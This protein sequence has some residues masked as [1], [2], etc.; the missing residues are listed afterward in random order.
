MDEELSAFVEASTADKLRRGMTPDEAV[1]A[2]RA[3]M[4]SANAVKHHIRSAAWETRLEILWLDLWYGVRSL[5]RSPGFASIAIL[6]LAL[7]IGANTAI[8]QLLDAVRLRSLPVR[9][10]SELTVVH[11]ADLPGG[12]GNHETDYP[13]LN[14]PLWEYIRDHQHVFSQVMAWSPTVLE[15]LKAITNGW[16]EDCG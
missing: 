14:N 9:N 10:P 4:G 16:F 12:R 11:L 6:T 7:G 1:H 15:L 5:A 8:F 2:A 3:E 13:A